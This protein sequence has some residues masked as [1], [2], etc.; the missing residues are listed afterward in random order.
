MEKDILCMWKY[1]K[2]NKK[3]YFYQ[4]KVDCKS[5]FT[6]HAFTASV[7]GWFAIASLPWI[8]FLS[9]LSTVASLSWVALTGMWLIA[10]MSYAN[11]F[12]MSRTQQL[13]K[14][15]PKLQEIKKKKKQ[16][17]NEKEVNSR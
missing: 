10:S 5:K 12:A 14:H 13:N 6:V 11:P 2:E 15:S 7:L 16:L 1:Q 4:E 9:E 17:C 3:L 8:T